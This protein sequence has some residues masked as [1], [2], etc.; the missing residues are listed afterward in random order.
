MNKRLALIL[1]ALFAMPLLLVGNALAAG[2]SFPFDPRSVGFVLNTSGQVTAVIALDPNG[3]VATGAPATP[4]GTF[5]T[6][7]ITQRKVGTATA[8]FQVQPDSSLGNLRFGCNLLDT[9]SRFL[10][11]APGVPGLPIGGPTL[12]GNW[13]SSDVTAKLFTQ[14]GVALVD[15]NNPDLVLRIPA[16]AGVISQKCVP[17]PKKDETLDFLMLNEIIEKQH[18]KPLPP[19]YPD[20]TIVPPPALLAQ[21]WFP[22]FLVLEVTIGFWA[23]PATPTP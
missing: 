5:G 8:T 7:A 14:L 4:T 16:I 21:Q 2:G 12:F 17:F 20:L 19:K 23:A 3:P 18:I 1:L 9:N 15:P 10:E 13:L 22:G 6:I 11:L